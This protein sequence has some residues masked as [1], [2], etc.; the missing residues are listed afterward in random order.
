IGI[1]YK[2]TEWMELE[3]PHHDVHKMWRFLE[4][5]PW[6]Y[7]TVRVLLDKEGFVKP[8]RQNIIEALKWLVEGAT[9]DHRLFLHYSGHGEQAP[10]SSPSEPDGYD[11]A[12]V[13]LDC[14]YEYSEAGLQGMIRDNELREILVDGLPIGCHLTALFDCCHSGSVLDLRFSY[15]RYL[16]IPWAWQTSGPASSSSRLN[17]RIL[18]KRRTKKSTLPPTFEDQMAP[19]LDKLLAPL[20]EIPTFTTSPQPPAIPVEDYQSTPTPANP[21]GL[22]LVS[23]PRST[24][25]SQ[26]ASFAGSSFR[27]EGPT[28]GLGLQIIHDAMTENFA[29]M[30]LQNPLPIPVPKPT[31]SMPAIEAWRQNIPRSE[32]DDDDVCESPTLTLSPSATISVE[33]DSRRASLLM[34]GKTSLWQSMVNM[35]SQTGL[36]KACYED[37]DVAYPFQTVRYPIRSRGTFSGFHSEA[38]PHGPSPRVNSFSACYDNQVTFE[39]HN[40]DGLLTSAF[41]HCMRENEHLVTYAELIAQMKRF[42][43]R[44]NEARSSQRLVEPPFPVLSSSYPMDLGTMVE[45]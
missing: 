33:T 43:I 31:I 45:I 24:L 2:N 29:K 27:N 28:I 41:I 10:T 23:T 1:Q 34:P 30:L 13:P 20:P 8:N 7:G 35:A 44:N 6:Q 9:E 40:G 4:E 36:K 26:R 17:R 21:Y 22:P 25:L 15:P 12:I 19:D 14:P 3:G 32:S 37:E 16:T 5:G 42:F 39:M 38:E 18:N 11:E